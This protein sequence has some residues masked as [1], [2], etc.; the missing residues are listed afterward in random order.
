MNFL[1]GDIDHL[2][3]TLNESVGK[4]VGELQKGL[5]RNIQ[6]ASRELSTNIAQIADRW[7]RSIVNVESGLKSAVE[8]ASEALGQNI[9]SLSDEINRH[10]NLT[11]EDVTALIDYA[12][13]KIDAT[14][15]RRVREVTEQVSALIDVK[16]S[17]LRTNLSEAAVEQKRVFLRNALI[18]VGSALAV[19]GFSIAT[20]RFSNTPLD[21]LAIYRIVFGAFAA[22]GTVSFGYRFFTRYRKQDKTRRDLVKVLSGDAHVFSPKGLFAH[23]GLL[24]LGGALWLV[25]AL[26]PEWF[27]L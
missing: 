3:E 27:G 8:N 17:A 18:A 23:L 10:R 5:D 1:K 4:G 11:K 24:V 12:C 20:K 14:L 13:G 26:R 22:G 2:G 25:L 9:K 15:D 19:A 21:A 16:V 6:T 7:D